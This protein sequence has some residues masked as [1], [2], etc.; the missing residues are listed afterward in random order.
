MVA[1][2]TFH[3]GKP[4]MKVAA[5]QIVLKKRKSH[6]RICGNVTLLKASLVHASVDT[7]WHESWLASKK[8]RRA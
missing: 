4:Q 8:Q 5:V 1:V 6:A 2:I 3:P 7:V